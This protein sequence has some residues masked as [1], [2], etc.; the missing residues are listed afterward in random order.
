M[1]KYLKD[2]QNL[3]DA[4][5]SFH[6]GTVS[7]PIY[8]RGSAAVFSED[9]EEVGGGALWESRAQWETAPERAEIPGAVENCT[10]EV[11]PISS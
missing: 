4:W 5:A 6:P 9:G 10:R 2:N 3:W 7:D 8:E 11:E 1:E